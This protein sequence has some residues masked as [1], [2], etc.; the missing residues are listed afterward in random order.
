M[1]NLI[2]NKQYIIQSPF[3]FFSKKRI[4]SDYYWKN[5]LYWQNR[6]KLQ[7]NTT[8]KNFLNI[9][10]PTI[11]IIGAG[12]IFSKGIQKNITDI[13]ENLKNKLEYKLG[14]NSLNEKDKTVKFF[15]QCTRALTSLIRKTE[16]VN[17]ITSLKDILFMKLMYKTKL[18]MK[19][20]K[21]ISNF[22]DKLSRKTVAK[23]YL[24]TEKSLQVME[25][26]FKMLDDYI[27]KNLG[28]NIITHDGNEMT[29]K[30]LIKLAQEKRQDIYLVVGSFISPKV[31]NIRHGYIKSAN[32]KLYQIFWDD[33]FKTFSSFKNKKMWQTFVAA[34]QMRADKTK[35]TNAASTAKKLLSC[36][37]RA[38]SSAIL[39]LLS[40]LK[41]IIPKS[42]LNGYEQVKKLEWF[43]KDGDALT[44][45]KE[46]FL[47]EFSK[48]SEYYSNK[49]TAN[50]TQAHDNPNTYINLITSL[51]RENEP[52]EIQKLIS[53]YYKVAPFEFAKSG[54]LQAAQN[55]EKLFNKAA[56]LELSEYFDKVRDLELGSAPTDV[57]TILL[58]TGLI[59]HDLM[60]AKDKNQTTSVILTSGIPLAGAV[61][62]T[63]ISASKL[64]SGGKS[65]ALGIASGIALNFIGKSVDNYRTKYFNKTK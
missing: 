44:T 15:K 31:Q 33:T 9:G 23:S 13:L 56:N 4:P 48:L 58:S 62:T 53:M 24:K 27:L 47:K 19:I 21:G 38:S 45:H 61:A 39:Q 42:D 55:T 49:I 30:E 11:L 8:E 41:R 50:I 40:E 17:N 25:A 65:L 18:T 2:E 16:S 34:D 35:I 14:I 26:R 60:K 51:I 32:E 22:F 6:H 54:A 57:L 63:I 5:T 28:N 43:A 46:I 20:H 10:L 29:V 3:K 52:G 64:V 36:S 1:N 37:D 7:E 59:S 12:L